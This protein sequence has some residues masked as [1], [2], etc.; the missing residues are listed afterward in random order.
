MKVAYTLNT[1]QAASIEPA[2]A[3][4][5]VEFELTMLYPVLRNTLYWIDRLSEPL[6]PPEARTRGT[7]YLYAAWHHSSAR[8]RLGRSTSL[9]IRLVKWISRTIIIAIAITIAC[10]KIVVII[11]IRPYGEA[12]SEVVDAVVHTSPITY[13]VI[14][15]SVVYN[16]W[17]MSWI[18][19]LLRSAQQRLRTSVRTS[20]RCSEMSSADFALS[21]F[22][23]WSLSRLCA[24]SR[25]DGCW[26]QDAL[27]L[28]ANP[29]QSR[30]R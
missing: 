3:R 28:R 2:F 30:E 23:G 18:W 26:P 21:F 5:D 6:Q 19:R 1:V 29:S 8:Y 17:L 20:W 27:A 13:L 12:R 24:S 10:E 9:D 16:V 4:R 22:Q 11:R 15:G 7:R 25:R 14:F